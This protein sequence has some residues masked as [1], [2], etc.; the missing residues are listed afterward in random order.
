LRKRGRRIASPRSATTRRVRRT[1]PPIRISR[2]GSSLNRT[3]VFETSLCPSG[4]AAR[5]M[6]IRWASS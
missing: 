2:L 5:A 4:M 3:T 6:R 1:T